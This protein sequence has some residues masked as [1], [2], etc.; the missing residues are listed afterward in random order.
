MKLEQK[1][2]VVL[3][4]RPGPGNPR[5]SEG[6][7]LELNDKR[8][9]F[10]YSRFIGESADDNA[11]ASVVARYSSDNGDTWSDEETIAQPEDHDATNIMS[12]SLL[13][14]ANGDIGLFYLLRF[15]W[16]DMRL[17]VRR[18]N[19]EGRTWSDPVCCVP[20]QGY[21]VTNND[22]VVR[23][24]SG[25]LIVPC[26]LHKMKGD[27][28]TDWKSWDSRSTAYFFLSDDDGYTWREAKGCAALYVPHSD[29]GL[30]E[31]G[32]LELHN[33][34]LWAWART[35]LGRQY[36]MFSIDGGETWSLPVPSRFTSPN[37]PLSMKRLPGSDSLVAVWN[38][39]PN[40][41]TRTIERHS[42]GRTPLIGA[43]SKDDGRT[44][45]G[46]FAVERDEDGGGYCYTAIHATMD[47]IL[48]AYCA[49][50]AEDGICL[51]RLKV[52]KIELSSLE[53]GS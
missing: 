10:A 18:S 43:I 53:M 45:S 7:F 5:N 17:H 14:M 20:G 25:R 44:W 28:R 38:P 46:R 2:T 30:Q 29:S 51:T 8:L 50:E 6:A 4:L 1:G 47:T 27:S 9:L 3:D 13:R 33:G 49:G 32:V 16:H 26:G 36:E 35:D 42:W 52:R 19:D 37:S 40:Y 39:V 24:S 23:L 34:V 15:G 22:R 12:V 31:P 21:Y 48:L 41:E 11:K